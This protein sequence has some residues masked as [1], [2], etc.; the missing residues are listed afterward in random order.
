MIDGRPELGREPLRIDR[1]AELRGLVRHVQ[2]HEHGHA[3]G[4]QREDERQLQLDARGV[5]DGDDRVERD[6]AEEALHQRLVVRMTVE[7]VDAGQIGELHHRVADEQAGGRDVDGHAGP[8]GDARGR[9]RQPVEERRLAG[10]R[11]AD[12]RDRARVPPGRLHGCGR[13]GSVAGAS[14]VDLGER[15]GARVGAADHQLGR[16]DAQVQR[17][18]E[19]RAAQHRDPLARDEARGPPSA[20]R[21][22]RTRGPR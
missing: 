12:H 16:P 20:R 14:P 17:P 8:V 4:L 10:V 22:S 6:R 3:G 7:R 2:D 5:D 15:D 1:D 11:R 21:P 13:S 19:G 18:A 9:A